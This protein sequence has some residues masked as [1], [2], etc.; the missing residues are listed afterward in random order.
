MIALRSPSRQMP[1]PALV[2]AQS[3]DATTEA[4]R[5]PYGPRYFES[6]VATTGYAS[7]FH[8][9]CD[10]PFSAGRSGPRRGRR[11]DL[12]LSHTQY[13]F[14]TAAQLNAWS[15]VNSDAT[16]TQ[17]G[18]VLHIAGNRVG[19]NTFAQST[20][21]IVGTEA[22]DIAAAGSGIST[23]FGW[24]IRFNPA[25]VPSIAGG[26][27]GFGFYDPRLTEYVALEYDGTTL[28]ARGIQA[29]GTLSVDGT[30]ATASPPWLRIDVHGTPRHDRVAVRDRQP[31]H[32]EHDLDDGRDQGERR[33]HQPR[34]ARVVARGVL[35]AA[36]TRMRRSRA[37]MSASSAGTARTCPAEA[38][39]R[40]GNW[41]QI[42]SPAGK[43]IQMHMQDLAVK[44]GDIVEAGQVIGYAGN[45]GYDAR[46][47]PV[48]GTHN[49]VECTSLTGFFYSDS[50]APTS[51]RPVC[52][53]G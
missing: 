20:K 41:V 45:T 10:L 53:R 32:D 51:S 35:A 26:V 33:V 14:E 9:G 28:T 23:P 24:E 29:A 12:R 40:F 44:L 5:S 18:T 38:I 30:T 50:D 13:G 52:C 49:H 48:I 42:L 11:A 21:F 37:A 6:H 15:Q 43:V 27:V 31:D 39:G 3:A 1:S 25:T 7:D 46:S 36:P 22:I 16:F 34:M 4:V 17:T 47:G 2:W 19:A 8:R